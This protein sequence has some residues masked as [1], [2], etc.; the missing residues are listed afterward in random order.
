MKLYYLR[1]SALVLTGWFLLNCSGPGPYVDGTYYGMS[2][3]IYKNESF[4]G[5]LMVVVKNGYI[6]NVDFKIMDLAKKEPFDDRYERHYAGN[7]TYI[8]QCRNDW[9]G[10]KLYPVRLKER[11]QIEKVDAVS[12]ATW[13][14]NLFVSSVTEAMKNASIKK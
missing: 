6:T 13:S 8:D 4:Y 3:S 12:G 1:V 11:Q 10:A 7:Q 2:Q 9:K 14:H 5:K